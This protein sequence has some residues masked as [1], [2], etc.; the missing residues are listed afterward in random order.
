MLHLLAD[1]NIPAS[2]LAALRARGHDVQSIR[3]DAPGSSDDEVL[4]RA[5]SEKRLLL[6]FDKDFGELVF[7]KGRDAS[8]GVVLFR[9]AA[10]S[11]RLFAQLA[12]NVL[13]GRNDWSGHF[14]VVEETRIRM[15][16][17]PG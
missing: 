9:I 17:L 3:E 10:M 4:R 6:T 2:A 12:V 14:S 7:R 8:S 1:E 5:I 13:E 11:P 16:R 15:T